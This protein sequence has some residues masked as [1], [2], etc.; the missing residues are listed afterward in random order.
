M[1]QKLEKEVLINNLIMKKFKRTSLHFIVACLSIL[2]MASCSSKPENLKL[3]PKD[4]NLVATTNLM[5]LA[6]K[7]KLND[8]ENFSIYK[9]MGKEVVN[10]SAMMKKM[11]EDPFFT[12]ISYT[13][14]ILFFPIDEN[15]FCVAID[16]ASGD[17][18]TTF[19]EDLIKESGMPAKIEEKESYKYITVPRSFVLA[20]DDDK[21]LITSST[22]Y[23]S[24][25]LDAETER[26]FTLQTADQI[27]SNSEFDIF[28]EDKKDL[29]MW[30]STN[31]IEDLPAYS[32]MQNE[33][34]DYFK[35]NFISMHLS[36]ETDQIV[37][38]V[39]FSPNSTLA[40][41]I[42]KYNIYGEGFNADLLA[43]FPEESYVTM[44]AAIN[45]DGYYKMMAD[46]EQFKKAL[47]MIKKETQM[48]LSEVM[49]SF[50]GSMLFSLHGFNTANSSGT[51]TP[52]MTMAFDVN[53]S[54]MMDE[55]IKKVPAGSLTETDGYYSFTV[56]AD[57]T[58]YFI[59]ND[60][61]G[62]ITND[63]S[64]ID[65]FKNGGD[66]KNL[67]NS[68][69]ASAIKNNV[70]YMQMNAK[71]KDYPAN[72]QQMLNQTSNGMAGTINEYFSGIEVI[73]NRDNTATYIVTT[74]DDGT[75]SLYK[76]IK[77]IDDN[78]GA[79]MSAF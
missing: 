27:S 56:D 17:K 36:F 15:V 53:D 55:L 12:G 51:P 13:S 45:P 2:F 77:A 50:K 19:V 3:V 7:G 70:M 62:L 10:Q 38:S 16:L 1:T 75:N 61:A 18:F 4:T 60:K 25:G 47:D 14:D 74:G 63:Q 21:A 22:G 6:T 64:R 35:D 24:K 29:N 73:V 11:V 79:L 54:K 30:V 20:W 33:I 32:M 66:A 46:Q 65:A 67:S 48:D 5:S 43:Y 31:L 40:K 57:N 52:I 34:P 9:S 44:S 76:M 23:S 28:Y 68:S 41:E 78:V 26:L 58:A 39:G 8:L 37:T 71:L 72:I 69:L 42:E 49:N 59:F